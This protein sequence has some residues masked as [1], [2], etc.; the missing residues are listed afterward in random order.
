MA[1]LPLPDDDVDPKARMINIFG[2]L[3]ASAILICG[4]LGFLVDYYRTRNIR[5]EEVAS[6][7]VQ[8]I[9]DRNR[10]A[11]TE[12]KCAICSS[13]FKFGDE[14][15]V[16]PRC[17]HGFHLKCMQGLKSRSSCPVCGTK[18]VPENPPDLDV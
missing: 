14:L 6:L 18:F 15:T 7:S 13:E 11:G 16:L 4:G 8:I 5:P 1:A 12:V 2:T 10:L 3:F 9:S 17:N